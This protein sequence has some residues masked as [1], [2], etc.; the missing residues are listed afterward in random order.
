MYEATTLALVLQLF[1]R[2][3]R[4]RKEGASPLLG[5]LLRDMLLYLAVY[6]L[7]V[8]DINWLARTKH[9]SIVYRIFVAYIGNAVLFANPD[10][11]W[12]TKYLDLDRVTYNMAQ[13][14]RDCQTSNRHRIIDPGQPDALHLATKK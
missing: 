6:D 4:S 8:Y 10:V 5:L 7:A 12:H 14:L 3:Q 1:V 2:Y 11:S 9:P 13:S